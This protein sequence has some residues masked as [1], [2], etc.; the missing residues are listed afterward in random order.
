MGQN[1]GVAEEGKRVAAAASS[2]CGQLVADC[3]EQARRQLWDVRA[4]AG[5]STSGMCD[6]A[7]Q[8]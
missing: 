5:C 1:P 4:T 6:C 3:Q 2:V 8:V 7:T